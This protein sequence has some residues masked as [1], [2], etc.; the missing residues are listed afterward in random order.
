MNTSLIGA[1]MLV[2]VDFSQGC[3]WALRRAVTLAERNQGLLEL[4]HIVEWEAP[5]EPQPGIDAVPTDGVANPHWKALTGQVQ[6]FLGHLGQFCS[7][8][9]ADRVPAHIQVLIGDP[10]AALLLAAQRASA[11][12]IVLGAQG[13]SQSVRPAHAAVGRTAEQVYAKSTVPVLLAVWPDRGPAAGERYWF[14]SA[15]DPQSWS[16]SR[17]GAVQGPGATV[18]G[19]AACGDSACTWISLAGPGATFAATRRHLAATPT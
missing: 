13:R 15:T 1:T 14:V 4:V 2:G 19:C 16:C 3:E 7:H 10:A 6:A 17:C 8:V 5:P 12:V 18:R 9:V 11:A